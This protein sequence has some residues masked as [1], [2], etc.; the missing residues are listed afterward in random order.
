MKACTACENGCSCGDNCACGPSC[1]CATCPGKKVSIALFLMGQ[2]QKLRTAFLV[3]WTVADFLPLQSCVW[4]A[5]SVLEP[6]HA[7]VKLC[8][9]L[10]QGW[11]VWL[12]SA[13]EA[14]FCV[15]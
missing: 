7:I 3:G 9:S 14:K 10:C 6:L 12:M 5:V 2:F 1:G 15:R 4:Y 11:F 8:S 13:R